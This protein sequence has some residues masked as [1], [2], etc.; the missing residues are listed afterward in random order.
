MDNPEQAIT[1]ECMDSQSEGNTNAEE[2]K[3]EIYVKIETVEN[4]TLTLRESDRKL[5]TQLC[6][7]G[8]KND[9]ECIAYDAVVRQK[10]YPFS[11][12]ID[13][14]QQIKKFFPEQVK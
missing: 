8:E 2:M 4:I 11:E 12:I 3:T 5:A 7:E 9:K 14:K 13:V 6:V 1:E 10:S